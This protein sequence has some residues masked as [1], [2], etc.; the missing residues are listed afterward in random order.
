MKIIFGLGNPGRSYLETRHNLGFM[1]ID[2]LAKEYGIHFKKDFKFS[3]QKTRLINKKEEVLLI[4]PGCFMN[5]SGK[6]VEKY[7]KCY[8][9]KLI[10]FLVVYDDI[11]LPFG[12]IRVREK[13]SSGGHNGMD[14]IISTLKTEKINRIRIG[15]GGI[16][17]EE[18]F[19]L[20]NF[21][22]EKFSQEEQKL[23]PSVLEKAVEL[24][25]KWL[26]KPD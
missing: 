10:D 21:V 22:L 20:A 16:K 17:R 4:K 25:K 11:A 24:C 18:N 23:L 26:E 14:S 7:L 2:N 5:N 15:I 3:V 9:G 8:Q 6:C 1:V 13:G 12:I 19:D